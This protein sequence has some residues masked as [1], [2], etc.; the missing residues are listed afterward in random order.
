MTPT[1]N[2]IKDIMKL[3]MSLESRGVLLKGT[4]LVV[5]KEYFS[6]FLRH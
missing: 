1:K 2:E 6:I 5:N 4:K 3:I